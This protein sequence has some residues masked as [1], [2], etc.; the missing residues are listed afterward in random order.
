MP[1]HTES[2]EHHP[3]NFDGWVGLFR[4]YRPYPTGEGPNAKAYWAGSRGEPLAHTP[5]PG[6]VEAA[7]LRAGELDREE[8]LLKAARL[9]GSEKYVAHC[10]GVIEELVTEALNSVYDRLGKVGDDPKFVEHVTKAAEE[11]AVDCLTYAEEENSMM[12]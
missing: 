6:T 10:K 8:A 5:A 4:K 2:M 12:R 7:A 11:Y 1:K 3:E 9:A